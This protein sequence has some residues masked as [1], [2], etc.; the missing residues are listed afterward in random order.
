MKPSPDHARAQAQVFP[1]VPACFRALPRTPR[2]RARQK[3]T[4]VQILSSPRPSERA[5]VGHAE[6]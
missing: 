3:G 1:H 2:A 4:M 5:E 6:T